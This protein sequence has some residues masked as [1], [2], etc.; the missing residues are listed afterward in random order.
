MKYFLNLF[1]FIF[2]MGAVFSVGS[3][4]VMAQSSF[5]I[6]ATVNKSAISES[7]VTDRLKLFFASSGM[8]ESNVEKNVARTQALNILIEEELKIQEAEKQNLSV[9]KEEVDAGFANLAQQNKMTADQFSI[10]L[11][12]QGV[13]VSTL[14]HQVK[15]QLAWVKVVTQVLRPKIDVSENDINA[16]M[17]LMKD[18]IGSTE[19]Q[20]F[21]IFLP[22][23][24][25]AEEVQ[26]KSLA[27]KIVAELKAGRAPFEMAAAQ[28]SKSESAPRGGSLGWVKEGELPKELDL[29]V[30]S[31]N[32]GQIS[33]PIRG[34][35][36]FYIVTVK[37]TRKTS[38]KT[39]PS[40]DEV[41]N[42]IG[43]QRLERLASRYLSDIKSAAFIDRRG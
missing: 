10:V 36:G 43:L 1:C 31:L 27:Q 33:S 9:T 28:F 42:N 8:P 14:R 7:D 21:D 19:Y 2:L 29:A 18:K 11:Q 40:E 30:R 12:Q 41:L 34:L 6:A 3:V 13:P 17:A 16:K 4:Q 32:K 37:D 20:A 24:N 22:V 26:I 25:E 38:D 15:A 35:G 39:L 5:A 23:E